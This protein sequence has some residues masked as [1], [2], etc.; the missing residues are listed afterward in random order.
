[1]G[2]DH[3]SIGLDIAGESP[4]ATTRRITRNPAAVARGTSG[5]ASR[6]GGASGAG[7]VGDADDDDD[8]VFLKMALKRSSLIFGDKGRL[9][10]SG[11]RSVCKPC[12]AVLC[13]AV[14]GLLYHCTIV[15]FYCG[16]F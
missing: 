15:G 5:G 10:E 16:Q 7:D 9:S 8:N 3:S 2:A 6:A 11:T 1:M 14:L 13:F 12:C 4:M